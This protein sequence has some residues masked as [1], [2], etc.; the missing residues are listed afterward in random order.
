[1]RFLILLL[2]SIYS[3]TSFSADWIVEGIATLKKEKKILLPDDTTYTVYTG[4][5]DGNSNTG[6]YWF[7]VCAGDSLVKKEKMIQTTFYCENELSDGNKFYM[8]QFR[9]KTDQDAGVG[10][11]IILGGTGVYKKLTGTSCTYAVKF[12]DNGKVFA[13][14][15]DPLCYRRLRKLKNILNLNNLILI[16]CAVGET[17]KKV[18]FSQR[19]FSEK[20][21]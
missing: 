4:Y 12:F 9:S 3:L 19:N 15:A 17:N 1:M 21:K 10:K 14:E 6:D 18:R 11:S 8:K 20:I 7:A 16:D 13:I 5:T 2:L